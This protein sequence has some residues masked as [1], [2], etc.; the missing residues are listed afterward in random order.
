VRAGQGAQN[1]PAPPAPSIA[2]AGSG[3]T[4]GS[5]ALPAAKP[6]GTAATTNASARIKSSAVVPATRARQGVQQAVH[7]E[8]AVAA[9]TSGQGAQSAPLA[10]SIYDASGAVLPGVDITLRDA[11]QATVTATTNAAG[12]FQ[13][14]SVAPG[15][16]VLEAALPG[17][18]TLR[19]K[20]DLITA[21]DWDRAITLQL[22][23]LSEKV[24]VS[25]TRVTAP[26]AVSQA[27]PARL[28]VGGNVRAPRKLVDVKP[29]YPVSM[30]EAG[31][32][33]VVSLDAVIGTDGSVTSVR[34]LSAD[35]HPDFAIAA[36]DA[37][38][39]WR[40]DPTQLNGVA[41]E[42]QMT[43]SVEFTLSK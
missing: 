27:K 25:A 12:R 6:A 40:F 9:V 4:G 38:R 5:P 3:V 11:Q 28:K 42:V 18:R 31:R 21:G 14:P 36:A 35:I 20:I 15:T 39:Q 8:P 41:V 30:R 34:V 19:Q 16:Y 24:V 22:G 43:V 37:V 2:R 1:A 32:E 29:E 10:G 33:A 26:T 13:F 7:A 17:F 23:Q